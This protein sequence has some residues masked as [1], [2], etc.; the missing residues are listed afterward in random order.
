[1]VPTAPCLTIPIVGQ[2]SI[3]AI[4]IPTQHRVVGEPTQRPTPERLLARAEFPGMACCR[5]PRPCRSFQVEMVWACPW[6]ASC[7]KANALHRAAP[8]RLIGQTLALREALLPVSPMIHGKGRST[9]RGLA[10]D[11]AQRPSRV[12]S[13]PI[14]VVPARLIRWR[15]IMTDTIRFTGIDSG[16]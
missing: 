3:P 13:I 10:A 12:H 14:R 16:A 11:I 8:G 7:P 6:A 1:M 15:P 9:V 4:A 5:Q 2:V